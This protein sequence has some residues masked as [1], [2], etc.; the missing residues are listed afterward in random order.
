MFRQF[1]YCYFL[2]I[3]GGLVVLGEDLTFS[4]TRPLMV[5]CTELQDKYGLLVTYED[6]P[7]DPITEVNSEV[8][9]NG[10][11]FLFPKWKTIT[12]HVPSGLPT[13]PDLTTPLSASW[14]PARR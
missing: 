8:H 10:V 11:T 6:A 1:V 13:R 7:G 4:R 9:S 12:F 14:M 2:L 3:C 5:L